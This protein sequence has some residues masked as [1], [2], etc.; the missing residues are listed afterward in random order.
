MAN[1]F[2]SVRKQNLAL[3]RRFYAMQ[4]RV[5]LRPDPN[6]KDVEICAEWHID[7]S[8]PEQA[9]INFWEDMGD[10]FEEHLEL[11]RKNPFEGYNPH[12]CRWVTKDVQMNNQRFHHTDKGRWL[13]WARKHWGDSKVTKV[14]F[15]SR[16]RR[17]WS[18]E[19]AA[20]ISPVKS[21]RI[22][23]IRSR[24]AKKSRK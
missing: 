2:R 4:Q 21:N 6:Y 12:N 8:G 11:D 22:H 24:R 14:R 15:H 13:T 9:F 18:P 16:V 7:I 23:K 5:H 19:E 3:W 1:F 17:G 20:R 10:D